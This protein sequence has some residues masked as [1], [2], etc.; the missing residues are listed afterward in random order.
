MNQADAY[1]TVWQAVRDTVPQI[2]DLA[3]FLPELPET[4][5]FNGAEDRAPA[6]GI[7]LVACRESCLPEYVPLI[8]ALIAAR[9]HLDWHQTY[10]EADGISREFLDS[11]G[12]VCLT[13]PGAPLEAPDH[14][15]F[16]AYWGP[17]LLYPDHN[18]LPAELYVVLAGAAVF[19]AEGRAPRRVTAGDTILHDPWQMHATDMIPGPLLALIGWRSDE[20]LTVNPRLRK[21]E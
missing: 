3:A 10:T 9:D 1:S 11:Y 8:D 20:D 6:P 12:Y 17:G 2:P 14:R 18:H 4:P 13:G 15:L 5:A 16:I 21:A 19:H 7:D